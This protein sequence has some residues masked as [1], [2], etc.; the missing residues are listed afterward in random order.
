MED[1]FRGDVKIIWR[2]LSKYKKKFYTIVIIVLFGATLGALIPYI[3]GK[4]VSLLIS[5]GVTKIVVAWLL[6]WVSF[7]Y[8]Y[9]WTTRYVVAKGGR[10]SLACMNDFL[11]LLN[12]H[13]INLK[14]SYHNKN[15]SGKL[16]SRYINAADSL[17]MILESIVFWFSADILMMLIA[18]ILIG[19]YINGVVLVIMLVGIFLYIYVSVKYAAPISDHI[20][21]GNKSYEEVYGSMNDSV[22]NIKLV[23]AN[24]GERYENAKISSILECET[25]PYFNRF[26]DVLN[27]A[28]F[29]RDI[30]VSSWTLF[31]LLAIFWFFQQGQLSVGQ[32]VAFIGYL[33]LVRIPMQK[34]GGNIGHY[35]RWMATVRRGYSLLEEETE[36]YEAKGK[37]CLSDV[38]GEIDFED[39][40][41]AYNET[42][43]VLKNI[44]LKIK[45]GEMVALVGESGVGKSTMMDL[46][47]KYIIPTSGRIL[48]DGMDIQ[49]ISL[50]NL[51]DN[52]AIVPQ[53]VSMFNDTVRNNI[54]Y[55]KPDA[56]EEEI[57]TA[58][59]ASNAQNF[60]DN[61]PNKLEEQVG[62]RGVQLSGGQKQRIAIARAILKN[63]KIL[64]LDEATSA[65]D[66]KS[67]ALVQEAMSRLMKDRTTF[68]IA[69]RLSTI[70]H[71]N[72]IVV[73]DKGQIIEE[74]T[75]EELLKKKGAYY[76]LYAM[77]SLA[78]DKRA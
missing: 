65:L 61:F 8:I 26:W 70:I 23:K 63:P 47:S 67:E 14:L 50:K 57:A 76:R 42:R 54:I 25:M 36:D 9:S 73:L 48:L 33:E 62:E 59:K 13:S 72:K 4:V 69:H 37:I 10:I 11:V 52:I 34:L 38:K 17:E 45:P 68:V 44:S 39:V 75:H 12:A 29:M 49:K 15:K 43:Q 46:L 3:Q 31:S 71:A 66:S 28:M 24:S 35:R 32:T 1:N 41:F 78:R 53:D 30:I 55:G 18:L 56:T 27:H 74:G 58:L 16:S 77:Q 5:D 20:V 6:L 22:A 51:R 7:Y 21:A 2:F 64:I 40:S 19:V 60:I